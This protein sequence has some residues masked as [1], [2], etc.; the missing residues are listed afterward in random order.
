MTADARFSGALASPRDAPCA[1][2][3][4][5]HGSAVRHTICAPCAESQMTAFE[6]ATV[7]AHRERTLRLDAAL[8]VRN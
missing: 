4:H 3:E 6:A 2:H 5:V 1:W 8:S 7:A